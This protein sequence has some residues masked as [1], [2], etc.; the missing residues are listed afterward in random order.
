[1]TNQ[2]DLFAAS[3]PEDATPDEPPEQ[4]PE[5]IRRREAHWYAYT[6]Y[7]MEYHYLNRFIREQDTQG[8]YSDRY[9]RL[10]NLIDDCKADYPEFTQRYR[11][12]FYSGGLQHYHDLIK[13]RMQDKINPPNQQG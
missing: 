12:T 4:P 10:I 6:R 5:E 1:M 8:V 11:D 9:A 13:N 7:V 3:E 2:I